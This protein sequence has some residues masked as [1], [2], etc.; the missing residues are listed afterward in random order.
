MILEALDAVGGRDYLAAQARENP[1]S[2][3]SLVARVIPRELVAAVSHQFV[4]HAP[5]VAAST[6]A[7]LAQYG[8]DRT[9]FDGTPRPSLTVQADPGRLVP[10]ASGPVPDP[11]AVPNRPSAIPIPQ[12]ENDP[13]PLDRI[14]PLEEVLVKNIEK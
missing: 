4:I 10:T 7:W 2:F 13:V 12:Y 9:V 1:Q 6:E 14:R 3:L 11:L 5:A 8:P